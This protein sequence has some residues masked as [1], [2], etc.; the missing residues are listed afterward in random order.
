MRNGLPGGRP[1]RLPIEWSG[2]VDG[3]L[4]AELVEG[5]GEFAGDLWGS[6]MLDNV[7][8]HEVD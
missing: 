6:G 2:L 7:A 3:G 5:A 8:L 4:G 1:F